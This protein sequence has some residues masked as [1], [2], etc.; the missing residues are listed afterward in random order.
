LL[1]S[2]NAAPDDMHSFRKPECK[3][4]NGKCLAIIRPYSKAGSIKVNAE[5]AGLPNAMIEILTR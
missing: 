4:F 1:A 2:G 3:T 5:A